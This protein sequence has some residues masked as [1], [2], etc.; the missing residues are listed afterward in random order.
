MDRFGE[1]LSEISDDLVREVLMF[2]EREMRETGKR[3]SG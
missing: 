1:E 2:C 3:D